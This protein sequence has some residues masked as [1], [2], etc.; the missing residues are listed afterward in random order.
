MSETI[1]DIHSSFPSVYAGDYQVTDAAL[2][3]Y[4][5]ARDKFGSTDILLPDGSSFNVKDYQY[6]LDSGEIGM[7]FIPVNEYGT[8]AGPDGKQAWA[9]ELVDTFLRKKMNL[10]ASDPLYAFEYY[11]HPELNRDTLQGFAATEKVEMGIT[12]LG[13]YYGQGVTSNSPPLYHHRSWG[14]AGAPFGYPC[15]VMILS[16]QGVDQAM[17]NK[18]LILTD[19][20]LNYGVRFPKDYKHSAFRMIDINTC[21]M[22]YRDWIMEENYLKTDTSWF[23]YCAAHKTLVTTVALNLPHNRA[24]FMEVYGEKEGSDFYDLFC[25]NYFALAGEEFTKDDE[26]YFTPLWKQEGFT[27]LQIRP[28]TIDEFYAYDAA[29]REGNLDNFD[30]FK[31]L[32]PT[33]ATGWGPQLAADVISN[34][35]RVYADFLHAGAVVSCSTIMGYMAQVTSRMG[36]S[37]DRYLTTAMPVLTTIVE[38]HAK[39]HAHNDED[40][41]FEKSSFYIKTFEELYVGY[42]GDIKNLPAAINDFPQLEKFEG[43]H[44]GFARFIQENQK[45]PEYLAWWSLSSVRAHWKEL[46]SGPALSMEQADQWL[47]GELQTWIQNARKLVAEKA[48][49]IEFNTPPSIVHMIEAGLFP[50]NPLIQIQTVCTVMDHTELETKTAG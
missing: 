29:R 2:K 37:E 21:L 22:F 19:K 5:V 35:V 44:E 24:S 7:Y 36:I 38:A 26:T 25:S 20:F 42:G 12:H 28:F 18:N 43:D 6:R 34:F 33:Q 46:L 30:G 16:L 39:V 32:A 10:A 15:N 17:L 13:A 9:S 49:T 4:G 14:V 11:I 47:W 23:T 27:T 48:G 45:L 50:K 1:R 3:N 41:A 40:P 8:L 31:P